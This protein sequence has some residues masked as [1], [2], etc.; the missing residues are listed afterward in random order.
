LRYGAPSYQKS[1]LKGCYVKNATSAYENSDAV[2]KTIASWVEKG[3]VAGPFNEPP[4]KNFRANCLMAVVQGKKTRP[5]LN[6]SLPKD[7]S[8]NSNI[9]VKKM[10]KVKMSSARNF[11]YSLLEAGFGSTF[12]KLDQCDA[13]KNV[14]V[15]IC[16]LN[17]Q[18]FEWKGKYFIE[19]RLIFGSCASVCLYDTVSDTIVK[20]SL[21]ECAIPRKFVHRTLDDTVGISPK[22]KN[23]CKEFTENFKRFCKDINLDLAPDCPEFVKAFSCSNYGKVLGIFFDSTKLAWKVPENKV[24]Q[25]LNDVE[26]ALSNK[27]NLEKMQALMGK[28]C[29]VSIMCPFMKTVQQNL[30]DEP[31]FLIENPAE[32]YCLKEQAKKDLNVWAGFLSQRKNG[33]LSVPAHIAHPYV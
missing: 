21:T 23:W 3:F 6:M 33:F 15:R 31:S 26:Y 19:T 8:F 4:V 12:S 7:N 20:V 28:L 32:S 17:K 13:Y 27:M 16:D 25:L 11:S 24:E 2:E 10:E 18:G 14:P 9:E 30:Y 5:L 1:E 29:N 22:S